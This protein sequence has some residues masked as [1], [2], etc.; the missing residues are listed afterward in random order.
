[1]N[2]HALC[3][4]L[5]AAACAAPPKAHEDPPADR[6]DVTH[7]LYVQLE[8]TLARHAAIGGDD[9]AEAARERAELARAA[10]EIAMKIVH[11]DPNADVEGLIARLESLPHEE[12]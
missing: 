3:A 12:K 9:S 2:R 8:L 6:A 5:L 10:D 7:A 11:I 1:M 4:A